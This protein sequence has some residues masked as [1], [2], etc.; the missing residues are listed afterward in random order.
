[1]DVL[2]GSAA[3]Y[4][5]PAG[6]TNWFVVD[7]KC[8]QKLWGAWTGGYY[9]GSDPILNPQADP[10]ATA[11]NEWCSRTPNKAFYGLSA[12]LYG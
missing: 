9:Q 10:I 4:A 5:R 12:L 8:R 6:E 1:M 3:P 7:S 2:R 11:F